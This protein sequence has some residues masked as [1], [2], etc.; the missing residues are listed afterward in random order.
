[1]NS[2]Y[3]KPFIDNRLL[4]LG[5]FL[6]LII[7][8]K[9][10]ASQCGE[11]FEFLRD[12]PDKWAYKPPDLV[13]AQYI[14]MKRREVVSRFYHIENIP[15]N[16]IRNGDV[17]YHPDAY[18][19]LLSLGSRFNRQTITRQK[20]RELFQEAL[21][22]KK[23]DWNNIR[24][25][26]TARAHLMARK[27][28]SMGVYTDKVWFHGDT[29]HFSKGDNKS[30]WFFHVSPLVYVKSPEGNTIKL[31]IDPTL[32]NQPVTLDTWI[33]KLNTSEFNIVE[34]SYPPPDN[35][36][37]FGV[38]TWAISNSDVFD[39]KQTL[40]S[41]KDKLKLVKLLLRK[42]KKIEKEL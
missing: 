5:L 40:A 38:A 15:Y 17:F 12:N 23:I 10:E 26:C 8:P 24:E 11:L 35:P 33:D 6:F 19:H 32:F 29:I 36:L 22:I 3:K 21:Q 16:A 9:A 41:E 34:T 31:I 20:A 30:F 13:Q 2:R 4:H 7:S 27:F 28:E 42:A 37:V 1:M 18:D 25:G 39:E 14:E